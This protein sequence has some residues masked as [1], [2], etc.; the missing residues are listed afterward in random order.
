MMHAWWWMDN[1]E[2]LTR[3]SKK[4]RT[5]ISKKNTTLKTKKGNMDPTKKK[6]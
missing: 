4:H 1:L 2:K 3:L 6:E 5:K